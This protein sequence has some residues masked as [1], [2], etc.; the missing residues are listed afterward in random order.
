MSN[1]VDTGNLPSRRGNK[2]PKIDSSTL[3]KTLVVMLD[4][5][6]PLAASV[7]PPVAFKV[8]TPFPRPDTELSSSSPKAP[9]PEDGLMTLLRSES[10][11]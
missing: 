4:P 11:A 8:D 1:K 2:R 6:G 3:S 9:P 10:L 5:T 7:Q